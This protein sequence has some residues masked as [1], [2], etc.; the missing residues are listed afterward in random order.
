MRLETYGKCKVVANHLD[1]QHA[2]GRVRITLCTPEMLRIQATPQGEQFAPD[3][4]ALVKRRWGRFPFSVEERE[5][6]IKVRTASLGI[7]IGKNPV[8]VT[9]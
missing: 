2:E 4:P 1:L 7:T 3:G 5:E 8:V 6:E 9:F